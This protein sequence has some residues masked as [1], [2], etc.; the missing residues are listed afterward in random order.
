MAKKN[1]N[2][3]ISNKQYA[4]SLEPKGE[5]FSRELSLEDEIEILTEATSYTKN[6]A[7]YLAYDESEESGLEN[8]RTVI[9]IKDGTVEIHRYG[10]DGAGS[11]DLH[12]EEGVMNITRFHIPMARVDLEIYTN[13]LEETLDEEG[14]GKI[15][16]DYSIKLDK[17]M[18]RRNKLEIE[19]LRS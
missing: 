7:L 1:V 12:L 19:V 18:S 2:I 6:D 15:Y 11:M 5:A 17:F 8:T 16:A 13:E 3:R 14:Y 10:E 9:K 4:E